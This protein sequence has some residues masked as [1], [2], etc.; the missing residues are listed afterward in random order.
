MGFLAPDTA[1]QEAREHLPHI[2]ERR[3][4]PLAPAF[5]MLELV[6]TL[7]QAIEFEAH[8]RFEYWMARYYNVVA[9]E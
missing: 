5:A 6:A 7:A 9:A 4:V 2:L 3:N 1:F 8:S